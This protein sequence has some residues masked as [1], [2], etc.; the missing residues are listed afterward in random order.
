MRGSNYHSGLVFAAYTPNYG[1][2][3]ANGGRYDQVGAAFGKA[4]SATGFSADLKALVQA[5]NLVS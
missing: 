4:R 5:A 2:S 1:S 3:I